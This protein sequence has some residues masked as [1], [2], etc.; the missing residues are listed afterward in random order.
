MTRWLVTGAGG[1]LGQDMTAV[2]RSAGGDVSSFDHAGLDVTDACAVSAAIR[3]GE[4][5]IVVNCAAWTAV[6]DAETHADAAMAVNG[7]G[8]ANLA[9]ACAESGA[10]LVQI[11]TDYVFDGAGVRPYTEH[12]STGPRTV[13]GQTKLAG[14]RA[15]LSLLPHSGYVLR[16]AWLYGAHGPCF[17][18]TM[19][20]LEGEKDEISVVNDQLGQ[21][22]WT[23]D[24][25]RQAVAL[26]ESGAPAGVYHATA[27]GMTSWHAL[28]QEVFRLLG[29]DPDRV[30]PT[31][32]S[33]LA[34]AAPRPAYSVLGH[35]KWRDA[36]LPALPNW[37]ASLSQA[38]P[39]IAA[40][41]GRCLPGSPTP[42]T[43][44]W[45]S[46]R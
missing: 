25:A 6:D 37:Q 45:P 32:S 20:R 2:L 33:T 8:P 28:A 21:P 11:S 43:P 29:A 39:A 26:I 12:D 13:Y 42:V 22:T 10:R 44:A 40:A 5:D 38:F 4:H 19:I 36:G 34:R 7:D 23:A 9:R 15:V 41:A 35:D 1:L 3:A 46:Y 27:S 24:V 18:K 31:S 17:I 16:T 30:A 14:E